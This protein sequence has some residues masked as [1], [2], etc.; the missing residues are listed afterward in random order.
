MSRLLGA[1][2]ALLLTTVI[3]QAEPFKPHDLSLLLEKKETPEGIKHS[4]NLKYMDQ[5]LHEISQFAGHYPPQFDSPSDHEKAR[6]E[7]ETMAKMMASL[8]NASKPDPNFLLRSGIL[9]DIGH[10]LDIPGSAEK[11]EENFKKLLVQYPN[12]PKANYLF[13]KFLAGTATKNKE[14]IPYLEKAIELGVTN[15]M[16]SLGMLYMVLQKREKAIELLESYLAKKPDEKLAGLVKAMREG[17]VKSKMML[18]G[19]EVP[20]EEAQGGK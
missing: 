17:K 2:L 13:G 19:K 14:A 5:I 4:F 20:M 3:A 11:A 9:H 6:K 8:T 1:I 12:D 7:V 16:Y 18:N 15:A 10:N